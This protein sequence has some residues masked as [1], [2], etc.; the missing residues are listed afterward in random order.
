MIFTKSVSVEDIVANKQSTFVNSKQFYGVQS[1]Y[2]SLLFS[3]MIE[4]YS[5]YYE[6]ARRYSQLI[7]NIVQM[8][9][10]VRTYQQLLQEQLGDINDEE[11]NTISQS[12]LRLYYSYI[13][14][15]K[16]NV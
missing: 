16:Y 4:K 14:M 7:Q 3:Y 8:Q 10:L 11:I 6:A 2:T 13:S 9:M 12:I 5:S 15:Q 1:I